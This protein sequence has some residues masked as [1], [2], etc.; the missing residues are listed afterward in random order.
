MKTKKQRESQLFASASSKGKF[1]QKLG[2]SKYVW[3]ACEHDLQHGFPVALWRWLWFSRDRESLLW[4]HDW[5]LQLY[6]QH[7]Q[8]WKCKSERIRLEHDS[9]CSLLSDLLKTNKL[10]FFYFNL[11]VSE[12]PNSSLTVVCK[13][14]HRSKSYYD[15][16]FHPRNIYPGTTG[17]KNSFVEPTAARTFCSCV[18]LYVGLM[19]QLRKVFPT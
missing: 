10:D 19:E 12:N 5:S 8:L 13:T 1:K 11:I 4:K 9:N 6:T 16:F 2:C 14:C 7:K 3:E 18:A 15:I 17:L